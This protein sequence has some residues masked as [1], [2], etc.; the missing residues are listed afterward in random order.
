MVVSNP[1]E[2]YTVFLGWRQYDVIWD[3]CV[4]FGLAWVPFLALFFENLTKPFESEFGRGTETSFRRVLI[5]LL[6]MI[7]VIM[8]CVS[9]WVPL[10][11]TDVSYKPFCAK[12]AKPSTVG[13][14]GTTY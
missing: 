11:T 12:N 1:L 13:D 14:S 9:P 10:H 5:E 8:F 7:F 2:L 3:A 4:E 6:M